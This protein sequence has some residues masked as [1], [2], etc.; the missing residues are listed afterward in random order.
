MP[1]ILRALAI[2]LCVMVGAGT[3]RAGDGPTSL[4]PGQHLTARFDHERRIA[5]FDVPL[6]STGRIL[7][8]AGGE[9]IWRTEQPFASE[10]LV[11]PGGI[12]Q[13]VDGRTAM[14]LPAGAAGQVSDLLVRILTGDWSTLGFRQTREADGWT[15]SGSGAGLPPPLS[16]QIKE[17]HARGHR[18]V[19]D[20]AVT[21]NNGDSERFRF[22]DPAISSAP[23]SEGDRA[24]LE[25]GRGG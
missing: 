6:R 17:I 24:T 23:L 5:G 25:R 14:R 19:D 2:C 21:R 11:T 3:V 18:F 9:L 10:L 13:I 8:T 7:L 15:A 22:H 16:T 4:Q 1:L 20:V 12:V